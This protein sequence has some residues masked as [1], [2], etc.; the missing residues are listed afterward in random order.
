MPIQFQQ[1]EFISQFTGDL[2]H[3]RHQAVLSLSLSLS[4][5]RIEAIHTT[6]PSLTDF[7]VQASA[8]HEDSELTALQQSNSSLLIFKEV[9]LPAATS[10][11]HCDVLTKVRIPCPYVPNQFRNAAFNS[12]HSLTHPGIRAT[13]Q[14]ITSKYVWPK[15]NKEPRYTVTL[16]LLLPPSLCWTLWHFDH[17]HSHWSSGSTSSI[18]WLHISPYLCWSIH[19]MA[20]SH[21]T[22]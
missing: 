7:S 4:L 16:S 18:S 20:K 10:T 14:V 12:H 1:L 11:L 21:T 19:Q 22:N 13:H 6:H 3:W 15:M 2:K 17:I 5:S 9:H 8:Q